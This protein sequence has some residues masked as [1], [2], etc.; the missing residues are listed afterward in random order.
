M[1][2]A[3]NKKES[4]HIA[5]P[6]HAEKLDT[7]LS[8][9]GVTSIKTSSSKISDLQGTVEPPTL[10]AL[11]STPMRFQNTQELRGR[12]RIENSK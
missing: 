6:H 7:F 8:A 5:N 2:I 10:A 9:N 1:P 3:K 12:L 4:S 11:S